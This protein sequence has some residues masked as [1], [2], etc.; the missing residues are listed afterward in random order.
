MGTNDN[1]AQL[2]YVDDFDS[3]NGPLRVYCTADGNIEITTPASRGRRTIDFDDPHELNDDELAE[4]IR[5][6]AERCPRAARLRVLR[7]VSGE[8]GKLLSR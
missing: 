3:R 4:L 5:F 8:L 6:L 2:R 1:P 7:A